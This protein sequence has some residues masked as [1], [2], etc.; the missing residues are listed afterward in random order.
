MTYPGPLI[1]GT[2]IPANRPTKTCDCGRTTLCN[3]AECPKPEAV[4]YRASIRPRWW[5]RILSVFLY[6]T[7]GWWA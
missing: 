2:Q 3:L 1:P 5:E 7:R 4:A 6:L